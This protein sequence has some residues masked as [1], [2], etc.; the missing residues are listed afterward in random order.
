MQLLLVRHGNT[1]EE[2]SPSVR[3]GSKTDLPLTVK[4]MKQAELL[5]SIL[6][7][8]RTP[9]AAI[10]TG[11][12]T[13]H[14]QH[15]AIAAKALGRSEA[16]ILVDN[17]LQEIDYGTWEGK[18]D[19]AIRQEGNGAALDAWNKYGIWPKDGVW[20]EDEQS[21]ILRVQDYLASAE[22]C[23]GES[24]TLLGITSGGVLRY[25]HKCAVDD[26]PAGGQR[27]SKVAPGNVCSL[28]LQ[29]ATWKV[30]YWNVPP[31]EV[32]ISDD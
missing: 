19:E 26:S 6:T 31:D 24:A 14:R 13:R 10:H 25:F 18:T 30:L 29:Q 16:A 17:R 5:G 3:V 9:I 21:L 23:A 8:L 20:G 32:P 22:H 2:G 11:P 4:G 15:G 28:H 1:F 7:G 12:L 27:S